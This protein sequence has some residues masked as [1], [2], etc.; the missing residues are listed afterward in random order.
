[1]ELPTLH[2]IDRRLVGGGV[3]FGIGWGLAGFCPGP[4]FTALTTG[5]TAALAFV[6]AM[7]VGMTVARWLANRPAALVPATPR[8]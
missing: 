4:A 2:S 5:G 8:T 3:L 6:A 7:L 1:M